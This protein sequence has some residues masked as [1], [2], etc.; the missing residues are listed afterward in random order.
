MNNNIAPKKALPVSDVIKLMIRSYGAT[1]SHNA[2]RIYM[3]WNEVSGAGES[4]IRRYYRDG[5]LVITLNSSVVRSA[6]L[7]Q[8][9]ALLQKINARIAQD[10]LFIGADEN[11]TVK[12]LV[13]K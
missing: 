9:E 2:Q 5:R 12:E 8:K 1:A 3:A 13:L 4:T 6:L 11:C 10:S 7:F